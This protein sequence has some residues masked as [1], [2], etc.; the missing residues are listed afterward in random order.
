MPVHPYHPA[1]TV[2][3]PGLAALETARRARR[4]PEDG[5]HHAADS[6][7]GQRLGPCGVGE[8]GDK[9]DQANGRQ[10]K[11]AD[12]RRSQHDSRTGPA[13]ITITNII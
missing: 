3:H 8:R 9:A 7:C 5:A 13:R 2:R 12:Q 1:A 10:P 6:H 11:R 4:P